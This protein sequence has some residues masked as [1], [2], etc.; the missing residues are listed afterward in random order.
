MGIERRT[1]VPFQLME[2]PLATPVIRGARAQGFHWGPGPRVPLGPGPKGSPGARVQG[3]PWGPGPRGN[4]FFP[5]GKQGGSA[6][7]EI[8]DFG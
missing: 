5:G 7:P 8:W 4:I 6:K 2:P 1:G 3:F